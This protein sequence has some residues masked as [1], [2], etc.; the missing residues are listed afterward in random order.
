MSL[1]LSQKIWSPQG[2]KSTSQARNQT[3][4]T[5]TVSHLELGLWTWM[6]Q[7]RRHHG[8]NLRLVTMWDQER[9]LLKV[10]LQERPPGLGHGENIRLGTGEALGEHA[11]S[12]VVETPGYSRNARTMEWPS[13]TVAGEEGSGADLSPLA[14]FSV[15]GRATEVELIKY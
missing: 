7:N 14:V 15:N 9:L 12:A 8:E 2:S 10:K 4:Y 6:L 5:V 1:G 13:K 11:A 3:G